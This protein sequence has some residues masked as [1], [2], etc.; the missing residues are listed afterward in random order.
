MARLAAA[1]IFEAK[2]ASSHRV[3][4][5]HSQLHAD[6]R[7]LACFYPRHLACAR[8]APR[9]RPSL[10]LLGIVR[11]ALRSRMRDMDIADL[12]GDGTKEIVLALSEGL[13]VALS[14][15]CQRLWSTGLSAAPVTLRCVDPP[16]AKRSWVVVGCQ[17]GTVAVLGG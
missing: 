15:K 1:G 14:A 13:V 8:T 4:I 11:H 17:D 12:N 6:Q 10:N 9:P 2:R 7:R 3:F 16:G 5:L